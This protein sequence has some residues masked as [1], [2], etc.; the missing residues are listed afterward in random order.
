MEAGWAGLGGDSDEEVQEESEEERSHSEI[1]ATV[2][3]RDVMEYERL[4]GNRPMAKA[5]FRDIESKN[6]GFYRLAFRRFMANLRCRKLDF[7]VRCVAPA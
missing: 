2:S 5:D 4:N 3:P 1:L 6:L 7:K